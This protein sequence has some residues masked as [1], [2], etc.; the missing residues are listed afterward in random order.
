MNWYCE[1]AE[2]LFSNQEDSS[3]F[4]V[5]R[6]LYTKLVD[7]YKKLLSFEIKSICSYYRHRALIVL[8]DFIKLDDWKGNLQAIHDA[9]SYFNEHLRLF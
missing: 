3:S 8:G 5:Q 7:L 4:G 6:E 9:E 1:L 2:H